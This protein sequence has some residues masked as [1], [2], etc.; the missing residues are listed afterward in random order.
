M[1]NHDRIIQ[2]LADA[3]AVTPEDQQR[4]K[5]KRLH[6]AAEW[7]RINNKG[8]G[9]EFFFL[10]VFIVV[11]FLSL[12]G[13]DT[14]TYEE[15][16]YECKQEASWI[17]GDHLTRP[18]RIERRSLERACIQASKAGQEQETINEKVA[19]CKKRL[20]PGLSPA[21]QQLLC[22]KG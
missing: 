1:D 10:A 13:C 18:E 15:V 4:A 6:R 14:R 17:G 2:D 5:T 19:K 3:F 12:A 11:C 7:E 20:K 16:V 9:V 8:R 22:A 21:L